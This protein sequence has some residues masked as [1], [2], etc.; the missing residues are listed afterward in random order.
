M[1]NPMPEQGS[2]PVLHPEY[3]IGNAELLLKGTYTQVGFDLV[4]TGPG[5]EQVVVG[6]YFTFQPP[7]NLIF[8]PGL[9]ISPEMVE[10]LLVQVQPEYQVAGPAPEDA[11]MTEVGKVTLMSGKVFRTDKVTGE[12]HALSKGDT[13]YKGDILEV[14]GRG[15][16]LAR[17]E[18][19]TR[20]NLGRNSKAVLKD[21][22]FNELAKTGSF[23]ATVMFGGFKYKSGKIGEF[24]AARGGLNNHATISTPSAVI[25]IR[26][27]ELEGNVDPVTLQ[28][29]VIHR[30]GF[31]TVT[32]IN[33][34]NPEVLVLP[35][36]AATIILGG[37]P[38]FVSQA[39]LQ[40]QSNVQE[41]LPPVVAE[42]DDTGSEVEGAA[43]EENEQTDQATEA[44]GEEL[45]ESEAESLEGPEEQAIAAAEDEGSEDEGSEDES[46]GEEASENADPEGEGPEVIEATE[47]PE[48]PEGSEVIEATEGPE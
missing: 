26:G 2:K 42:D 14:E 48:G 3:L 38:Q 36:N 35:G 8:A 4:I 19:G 31:L 18:D 47:G 37:N 44:E 27:S 17:M 9:G 25:G 11:P 32:D 29:T 1:D 24:S 45:A 46:S 12:K 28:T 16:L 15:Y 40:Q 10:G 43:V 6:D 13:L 7:P 33:G 22:S 21:Y 20:F 41:A 34:N 23:E 30:S 39:S 5:G